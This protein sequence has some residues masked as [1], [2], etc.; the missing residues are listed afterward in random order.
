[1]TGLTRQIVAARSAEMESWLQQRVGELRVLAEQ[2]H[3]R[4]DDLDNRCALVR[5][6]ARS[7]RSDFES[8]GLVHSGGTVNVSDGSTIDI[9]NRA[10][11]N[12]MQMREADFAISNPLVSRSDRR[13]IVVLLVRAGTVTVSGAV[14]LKRL[15]EIA[16]QIEVK[17]RSGWIVD[18]KGRMVARTAQPTAE[19]NGTKGSKGQF[20]SDLQGAAQQ[21][22]AEK[23][24]AERYS[25]PD[26]GSF[27]LFHA[28]IE[29]TDGWSLVVDLP[30][31]RLT[32]Q[33]DSLVKLILA[34]GALVALVTW[35]L[36]LVLAESM[37]RPIR[38][39]Q[40]LMFRAERGALTA[41]YRGERKDEIG[42]L[43]GSF[44]R[45]LNRVQKLLSITEQQQQDLREAELRTMQAQIRPHFLYNTLDTI[46]WMARE[47]QT[48][49][50]T[51]TV[52][53]LTRLYRIS[54]SGGAEQITLKE[55]LQQVE[56]Y[57][58]IQQVRYEDMFDYTLDC[59][60]D[61]SLQI[62][63]LILQPVV[64]N[65]LYHGIKPAG[66]GRIALS[67]EQRGNA[68]LLKVADNG[69]GFPAVELQRYRSMQPEDETGERGQGYGLW[70]VHNRL[71][72]RYGFPY[73]VEPQ[74]TASGAMVT[75][76]H[77]LVLANT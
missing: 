33:A 36:A 16:E 32:E 3:L 51:A 26:G 38:H 15:A 19:P 66:G 68:L 13:P 69:P 23:P 67:T 6:F 5:R 62:M 2:L 10:Y 57:L 70:N 52:D 7:H 56:S 72:L 74:N 45:M 76:Y 4:E 41:R 31:N 60:A 25:K 30:L 73:G 17:G 24:G 20:N 44:N 48:E 49:E 18:G 75:I 37:A 43:G 29:I 27:V 71:R 42:Q 58:F 11:Y 47:Q 65:A 12:R 55:E 59:S 53:A 40:G 50:L 77:P 35:L 9:S 63:K 28:P 64:E 22:L 54:L 8:A 14:A 34:T 46:K 21:L 39:L 1:V 61:L